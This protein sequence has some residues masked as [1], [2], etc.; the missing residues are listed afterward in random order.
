MLET[1]VSSTQLSKLPSAAVI[2]V[3]AMVGLLGFLAQCATYLNHDVAWVLYSSGRL[4]DGGVFGKDIIAANPPLIWWISLIPNAIS[5]LLHLPLIGTFRAFMLLIVAGS[6]IASERIL[7]GGQVSRA[8]RVIFLAAAAYLLTFGVDRDF[9]QREHIAVALVLPYVLA[10]ARRMRGGKLPWGRAALI[11]AAAGIGIAFKPYFLLVPFLLEGALF[12]RRRSPTLI[13]RPEVVAAAGTFLLYAAALLIFARPWMVEAVP[14]IAQVYWAFE[15]SNPN[16]LIS[17]GMQFAVPLMGLS[18][19]LL[20]NRSD[21]SLALAL[22]AAGF[23][24]AAMIQGKYYSYH[25]FPALAFGLLAFAVGIPSMQAKW[26]VAASALAV[27]AFAIDLFDS[28]TAL[29]L[30]TDRGAYGKEVAAM[31]AFVDQHVPPGGAFLAI[32]THPFPGFPTALYAN[33]DW[34]SASNSDLFLP[35]VVRLRE[36]SAPESPALLHLSQAKAH[37]AMLRDLSKEPELVLIDVN[38]YRHAIGA[39]RFD[40]LEF[41]LED[42]R[43]RR[44]WADYSH[45]PAAIP[46]YDAYVR[47]RTQ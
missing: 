29:F 10:V 16:L 3:P 39:S 45:V 27:L 35:A 28:G 36:G 30:R 22:A 20:L 25:V 1:K 9:G 38:P 31:S 13:L 17:I 2:A 47:S 26:R 34:A 46:G 32:S 5:R 21:E 43:F 23:L 7:A 14:Q 12:W 40:F 24:V 44:L 41:Y 11:G 37:D 6:L 42:S 33:R 4:I 15:Q 18:L 19:V 8:R